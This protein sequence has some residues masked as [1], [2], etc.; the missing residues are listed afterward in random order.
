MSETEDEDEASAGVEVATGVG[1]VTVAENDWG[2]IFLT[3]PFLSN[4]S[5][6]RAFSSP[7]SASSSLSPAS[8]PTRLPFS[9]LPIRIARFI[10]P[11]PDEG[12][13][14]APNECEAKV[15]WVGA[16]R[17]VCSLLNLDTP[18]F[19]VP[20]ARVASRGTS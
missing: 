6:S 12:T 16:A 3:S 7:S 2:P 8:P 15:L 4:S 5:I 17:A 1:G 9:S 13:T 14:D 10:V 20:G 19:R 18:D 11:T